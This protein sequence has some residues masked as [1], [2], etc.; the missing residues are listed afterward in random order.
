MIVNKQLKKNVG[1]EGKFLSYLFE[2][3]EVSTRIEP[4]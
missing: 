2:H 4:L 3:S 1:L